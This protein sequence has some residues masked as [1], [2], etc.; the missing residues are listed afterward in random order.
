MIQEKSFLKT[1][2]T[3]QL[4]LQVIDNLEREN[5]GFLSDP[6]KR[7]STVFLSP[8]CRWNSRCNIQCLELLVNYVPNQVS[9][10]EMQNKTKSLGI[11]TGCVQFGAD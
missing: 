5:Y 6:L 10:K 3:L 2:L 4:L 1:C 7:F 8:A 11:S 9:I